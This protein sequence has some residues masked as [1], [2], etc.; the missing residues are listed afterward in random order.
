MKHID[1]NLTKREYWFG[2]LDSRP[3]SAFRIA[4][5]LLLL[6]DAV[7]HLALTSIFYSD[8]GIVPRYALFEGLARPHRFSLMDAIAHD[9]MA[10]AFFFLWITVLLGLLL[11]YRTRLMTVIN[12]ILILSIHERNVYV[13]TGADTAI[14]VFSFWI[15]FVPLGH[16]Y[17]ID[18]LRS[19]GQVRTAFAFPVRM[20][21]LQVALIYVVTGYLKFAGEIWHDG[22]ALHYVL[23]LQSILFPPGVWL[24]SVS[25]D[26]LLRLMTWYIIIAELAF[27]PLVFFPVGQPWLRALGL[28]LGATVHLGIAVTMAIPDFS[29]VMMISY[30]IFFE[31]SWI[32]WIEKHLPL[33]ALRTR[34]LPY[35]NSNP[36]EPETRFAY[37]RRLGLAA[38]LG[39]FMVCVIWWNATS[40][41][42]YTASRSPMPDLP[43]AVMWY[44]GL[45]QYWDLYAPVPYQIDGQ[46]MI[47]GRFED[48]MEFDL[49]AAQTSRVLWGPGMRWR[50]FE[51]NINNYRY[52]PL[53]R[54]WGRYYCRLYN[55]IEDRPQG[56][57]LTT[58]EIHFVYRR[59]YPPGGEINPVEDDLLWTHWC[60]EEYRVLNFFPKSPW[61]VS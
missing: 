24:W 39:V 41:T 44:S 51:E 38:L 6:K 33:S 42:E 53:L 25:P 29:L 49:Y 3:L 32:Q 40:I 7:Y 11:G 52:D 1:N 21:Q 19:S 26:W 45:W 46:I 9:W 5:A 61:G 37:L 22:D 28:L 31:S 20:F 35:A 23:Q 55:D 14:R 60:Y 48:G 27:A 15:M 13:L 2:K 17:S 56:T 47:P 50:K 4:F 58:L 8:Q 16:Y 10:A 43:R 54:A 12:F 18:S 36:S 59:S 57:R 30:L 34:L